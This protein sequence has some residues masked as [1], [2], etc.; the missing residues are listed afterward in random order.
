MKLH[1]WYSMCLPISLTIMCLASSPSQ[2]ALGTGGRE[3]EHIRIKAIK[4]AVM[5]QLRMRRQP[6]PAIKEEKMYQLYLQRVRSSD[7]TN[8]EPRL[9]MDTVSM[10]VHKGTILENSGGT[11]N[12]FTSDKQRVHF[13]LTT[14]KNKLVFGKIKISRG[15]LKIYRRDE[16]NPNLLEKRKYGTL[17]LVKVYQLLKPAIE[18]KE[19]QRH[20]LGSRLI[21]TN[22]EKAEMVDI[23]KT[24][25]HWINYPQEN[26]G[27][28]IVQFPRLPSSKRDLNDKATIEAEL[29]IETQKVFKEVRQ[30]RESDT[31]DCQRNQVQCCRRALNVSFEAIGWSDW[32]KAPLNYN[33]FYCDGTCPPKYKLATMHT[34]IQSNMNR[35]SHGAVRTPC[36]V[37]ASYEPLTLLHFNSDRK[38]TATAFDDMIVS[39]CHCS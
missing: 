5:E 27:L 23:R 16:Q 35:V 20:L 25:Q 38:L 6:E 13:N 21:K 3:G 14:T 29:E 7:L 2:S 22:S 18:R 24:V 10:F 9:R 12:Y 15:E 31:E 19:F 28:E 8:R 30:R 4:K 17:Q 34:L 37:P 26:F 36:C 39:K 32:V 33:A 1:G 11:V